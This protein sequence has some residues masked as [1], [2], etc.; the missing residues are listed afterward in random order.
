MH[1]KKVACWERLSWKESNEFYAKKYGVCWQT[2]Y[3]NRKKYAPETQNRHITNNWKG[4]IQDLIKGKRKTIIVDTFSHQA[5]VRNAA[6]NMGE[7]ISSE[8][9]NNGKFK[10]YIKK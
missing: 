9:M 4:K 3:G 1:Y 8:T 5:A 10:M 7:K 6:Y 2:V